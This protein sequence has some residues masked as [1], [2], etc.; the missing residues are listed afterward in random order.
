MR[1]VAG[2]RE[3]MTILIAH[4]LSTIMHA[5]RIYVLERGRIVESGG[6]DEL[7]D[8]KGLYFAMWRQQVGE[9]RQPPC[10]SQPGSSFGSVSAS[11]LPSAKAVERLSG[12]RLSD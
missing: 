9:R 3:A 5:D 8:R 1:D 11:P 4:R 7:L 6:H 2:D 12:W 10:T